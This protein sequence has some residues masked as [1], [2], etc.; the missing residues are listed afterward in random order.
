[1]LQDSKFNKM[2]VLTQQEMRETVQLM[3]MIPRK[4]QNFHYATALMDQKKLIAKKQKQPNKANQALLVWA[5]LNKT[6]L[7]N[8]LPEI[9]KLKKM[10]LRLNQC[11]QHA[12]VA[13]EQ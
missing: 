2:I 1:M 3:K 6:E 9:T 11:S 4:L 13:M 7:L 10:I 8:H 12:M 5:L